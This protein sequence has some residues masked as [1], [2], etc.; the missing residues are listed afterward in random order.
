MRIVH[1]HQAIGYSFIVEFVP[2][3]SEKVEPAGFIGHKSADDRRKASV[4]V[5]MRFFQV[6]DVVGLHPNMICGA[7]VGRAPERD[8]PDRKSPGWQ[9]SVLRSRSLRGRSA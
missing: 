6:G 9:S 5:G 3:N 7:F 2:I 4:N 1:H 8:T